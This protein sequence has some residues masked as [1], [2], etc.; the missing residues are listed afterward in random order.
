MDLL[1]GLSSMHATAIF[2]PRN[3]KLS[4]VCLSSTFHGPRTQ[5]LEIQLVAVR[6][7]TYCPGITDKNFELIELKKIL[8]KLQNTE[9]EK[10][11]FI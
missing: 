9:A 11:L 3:I 4:A 2:D 6:Y 8:E 7:P 10:F 5:L 1:C